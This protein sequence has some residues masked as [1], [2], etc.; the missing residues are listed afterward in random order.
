MR[1]EQQSLEA[2][3]ARQLDGRSDWG[4]DP[5]QRG[6]SGRPGRRDEGDDPDIPLG[7][8]SQEMGKEGSEQVEVELVYRPWWIAC[9]TR[10]IGHIRRDLPARAEDDSVYPP[11]ALACHA[12][13]RFCPFL[14]EIPD[15]SRGRRQGLAMQLG[16][17]VCCPYPD[18]VEE[19][20]EGVRQ[21][22]GVRWE[23]EDLGWRGKLQQVID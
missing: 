22:G 11:A 7:R 17:R 19:R 4:S 18:S 2:L 1:H 20:H 15:G 3:A 21:R 23:E 8:L 13:R 5:G 16:K 12:G 10:P 9:S 6:H 14:R